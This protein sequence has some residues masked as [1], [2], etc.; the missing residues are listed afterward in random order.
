MNIIRNYMVR[1]P[2]LHKV[3]SNI[4]KKI[5]FLRY[6]YKNSFDVNYIGSISYDIVGRGN[7]ISI[8][9]T[10]INHLHVRIRGNNNTLTINNNVIIGPR[11]SIWIKGDGISIVIGD[12]TTFTQDCHLCAQ[13]NDTSIVIGKDCMFSNHIVVRTSDSHPY[14]DINSGLRLNHAKSVVI[15]D[16]VWIAPNCKIMK[17]SIIGEGCI[18]GSDSSTNKEYENTCLIAGRPAKIIRTNVRWTREKLF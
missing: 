17:G 11:C 9:A 8:H 14:Y 15:K 13:E 10:E 7:K 3:G 4:S 18:I 12:N 1:I 16:H 6:K 5:R 2:L